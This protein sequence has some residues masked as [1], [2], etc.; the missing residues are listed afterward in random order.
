MLLGFLMS[1]LHLFT[2]IKY[3]MGLPKFSSEFGGN[4][5]EVV[6]P[7]ILHLMGDDTGA[8][9]AFPLPVVPWDQG[10]HW[11]LSSQNVFARH[12]RQ[13]TQMH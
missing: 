12:V 6:V 13:C 7:I 11:L 9:K 1:L 4:V 2:P 10:Q 5:F 8:L 3:N